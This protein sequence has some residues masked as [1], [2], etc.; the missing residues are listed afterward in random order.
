MEKIKKNPET[1]ETNG[2]KKENSECVNV[3]EKYRDKYGQ[4]Q[5]CSLNKEGKPPW[6]GH[7]T[8]ESMKTLKPSKY[9]GDDD[10]DDDASPGD[11][12]GL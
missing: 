2:V 1:K 11:R 9:N 6:E 7:K 4:I 10:D 8:S 3:P 12:I 5:M